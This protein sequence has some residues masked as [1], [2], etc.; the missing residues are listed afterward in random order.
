MSERDPLE[1]SPITHCTV[2]GE[3]RDGPGE[4]WCSAIHNRTRTD[5]EHDQKGYGHE[6]SQHVEGG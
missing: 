5:R 6:R 1:P 4:D 3:L 2:C